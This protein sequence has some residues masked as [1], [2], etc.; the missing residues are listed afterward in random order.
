M[1]ID[2]QGDENRLAII[3]GY[4]HTARM[5]KQRG[6]TLIETLVAMTLLAILGAAGLSSWV[7]WQ[8]QQ[9]LWQTAWQVRN[10]LFWLRDDANGDNRNHLLEKGQEN[11][12]WCLFSMSSAARCRADNPYA[13]SAPWPEV[14]V[15]E[16][17]SGLGFYG[18]RNTA[19]PGHIRLRS[20][21]GEWQVVVSEQGRIRM[22][23]AQDGAAC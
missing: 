9:H 13:L 21:A 12:G 6:Y 18:L 2:T 3:P 16:L 22:C 11:D 1:R 7:R 17:T 14:T 5:E 10:F 23:R 20:P 15:A 8:Q 4:R 19:W